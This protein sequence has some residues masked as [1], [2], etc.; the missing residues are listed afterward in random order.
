MIK[1]K[2]VHIIGKTIAGGLKTGL[3]MFEYISFLVNKE[4]KKPKINGKKIWIYFFI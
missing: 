3:I 4:T 1:Y 2:I